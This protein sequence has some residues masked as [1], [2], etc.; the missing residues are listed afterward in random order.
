MPFSDPNDRRAYNAAWMR[1]DRAQKR[2]LAAMT[3]AEIIRA[4]R[5]LAAEAGLA[6]KPQKPG[7]K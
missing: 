6:P 7:A 5:K 2:K 4:G 3:L 1:R